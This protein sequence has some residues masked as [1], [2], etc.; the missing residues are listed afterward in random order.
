MVRLFSR[1]RRSCNP[2]KSEIIQATQTAVDVSAQAEN[3]VNNLQEDV[4][5]NTGA[6]AGNRVTAENALSQ[7]GNALVTAQQAQQTAESISAVADNAI[8][9]ATDAQ[10]AVDA[11]ED[12]LTVI[13]AKNTQQDSDINDLQQDFIDTDAHLTAVETDLEGHETNYNNPHRVTAAQLGL[14]GA[15][16]YKGQVQNYADL[17][18]TGNNKG[19]TWNV[20]NAYSSYPAHSNVIWDGSQWDNTGGTIDFSGIQNQ[21]DTLS[22]TVTS[23]K[24]AVDTEITGIKT[25]NTTQTQQITTL[26]TEKQDKLTA[27]A[28]IAIANGVIS[29][30][31]YSGEVDTALSTTSTNPVTNKAITEAIN[32]KQA[33]GNYALQSDVTAVASDLAQSEAAIYQQIGIADTRLTDLEGSLSAMNQSLSGLDQRITANSTKNTQQDTDISGLQTQINGKQNTLTFDSVPTANSSNPV[34]SGGVY[35]ALQG[36]GGGEVWEEVDLNNWPTDWVD[37]DRVKVIFN[38]EISYNDPGSWTVAPNKPS[39]TASNKKSPVLEFVLSSAPSNN[40]I[41]SYDFYR[42]VD[43]TT[44][45]SV[46]TAH[47]EHYTN[48]RYQIFELDF[49]VF[50]NKESRNTH[51]V[52]GKDPAVG[53]G[54]NLTTYIHKLWRL[55]Q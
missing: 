14:T 27:G 13:H 12:E 1:S 39:Y 49:L 46:I 50:N 28:G 18:T 43:Y 30:T 47:A 15:L 26:Q 25:L 17:P 41:V 9:L 55:K 24:A 4:I 7:A 3:K 37:G 52:V 45:I 2:C 35:T 8:T 33:V 22:G 34:T 42:D 16:T 31:G 11:V 53:G 54:S 21:I 5:I 6:I 48:V 40:A 38:V 23:N 36:A 32:G 20:V 10:S 51:L 19:D 29:A 44:S